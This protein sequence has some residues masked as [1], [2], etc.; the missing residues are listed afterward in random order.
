[1]E[2]EGM[3]PIREVLASLGIEMDGW[4]LTDAQGIS[5]GGRTIVGTGFNPLGQTGGWIV[6]IPEP[7]TAILLTIGFI[8]LGITRRQSR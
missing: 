5:S 4:K 6:V 3:Q 7:S 2:G 1:M 8:A